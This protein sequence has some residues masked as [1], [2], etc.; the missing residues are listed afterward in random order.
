[1]KTL[2]VI[3][4][5]IIIGG[6]AWFLWQGDTP[7][8]ET[9]M[10][11]DE[12]EMMEDEMGTSDDHMDAGNDAMMED[13]EGTDTGMEFPTTDS[14]DAMSDD[15]EADAEAKVFDIDGSNFAFS[16]KEIRVQEGDTVTINLT[17]A[18][19]FHD[20]NVDEFDAATTRV[21]TGETASVTFVADTAGTYEYYC[22]VG[23]HRAMGMVGTLIV[24]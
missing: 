7:I 22:S 1:M 16:V 10:E 9:M 14:G 12:D 6:G 20:W 21:N 23:N 11:E 19:G 18:D 4:I 2:I 13:S 3:L 15:T 8:D 17:S 24:E 5:L